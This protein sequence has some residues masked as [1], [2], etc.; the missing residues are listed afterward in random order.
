MALNGLKKLISDLQGF[1]LE[2]EQHIIVVDNRERIADI[3]AAQLAE[4]KDNTGRVREDEYAPFTVRYKREFG[5]GLG[6]VTDRVTFYM[7]G[8]LYASFFTYVSSQT[9]EVKSPLETYGKMIQRVGENNF[10]LSPDSKT[11][12]RDEIMRPSLARIF[13]NKTGL[14]L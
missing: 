11:T 5:Q 7:T 9:V 13:F 2:R 8:K 14:K 1:D 4:G 12:F 3:Q 6:K 10:G